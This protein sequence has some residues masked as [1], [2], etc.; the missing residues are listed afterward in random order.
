[1][2]KR[3]GIPLLLTT[4]Y[5]AASGCSDPYTSQPPESAD[6]TPEGEV[7]GRVPAMERQRLRQAS[8]ELSPT[9]QAA[10]RAFA[11]AYLNW[12]ATTVARRYRALSREAIGQARQELLQTAASAGTDPQPVGTRV[13]NRGT[14]SGVIEQPGGWMLVVSHERLTPGGG[15]TEPPRH[16]VYRVHAAPQAGGFV[17]DHWQGQP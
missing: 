13:A 5:L 4:L 16:R 15:Q 9:P 10:A 6:G 7:P 2:S 8:G 17:V 14:V 3:H 12:T 1:M 11:L